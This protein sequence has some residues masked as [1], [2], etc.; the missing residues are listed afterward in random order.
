MK[1]LVCAYECD[2]VSE[3]GAGWNWVQ[4]FLRLGYQVHV[5]TNGRYRREV[6][7]CPAVLSGSVVFHYCE[8][9]HWAM[10]WNGTAAGRYAYN[11]LWQWVAYGF[12][13]ELHVLEKFNRVHHVSTGNLHQ[14]SFMGHLGIPFV[15]GPVGAGEAPPAALMRG[16]TL[17]NRIAQA[18]RNA[19][20]GMLKMDPFMR[21]TFARAQMIAC[22]TVETM[23]RIPGTYRSRCMV[24][25][26]SAIDEQ[27]IAPAPLYD[28]AAPNFVFSGEL[29]H[30]DGLHLAIEALGRV[31]KVVPR[32]RLR[33]VGDGPGRAWMQKC[34]E[35][36]GVADATE[37]LGPLNQ[38]ERAKV[39][40]DSVALVFPSLCDAEG[41]A[42][43]EALAAALPVVCLDLGAPGVL[44]APDCACIVKTEGAEEA[45][46]VAGLENAM[47]LLATNPQ[48][49]MRLGA[50]A[51]QRARQLTW[52]RAA[53]AVCAGGEPLK[54]AA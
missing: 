33:I 21:S 18:W 27:E 23:R 6:L 51:L 20:N 30:D 52:E 53:Q 29:N 31:R 12:A 4:A 5:I 38:E 3:R 46:V 44:A 36:A 1:L 10:G 7:Q 19:C 22:T 9:P 34:A 28:D 54:R 45:D 37:W 2:P 39:L 24:Q 35:K 14:P 17:R 49:R 13:Q 16:L 50:Q 32:A 47:L 8:V 42:V 48:L 15:Y 43:L 40:Q 26:G 41:G 11:L 25:L